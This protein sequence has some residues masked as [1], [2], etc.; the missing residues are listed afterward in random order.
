MLSRSVLV[1][2][3]YFGVALVVDDLW[4]DG[5]SWRASVRSVM[6]LPLFVH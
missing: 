1:C 2:T 5:P 4:G 6:T 3:L